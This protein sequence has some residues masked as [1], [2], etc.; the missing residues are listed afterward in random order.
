MS[1]LA[2]DIS[3]KYKVDNRDVRVDQSIDAAAV[4]YAGA[5]VGINSSSHLGRQ[6]VSGDDFAG[7][8]DAQTNNVANANYPNLSNNGVAIGAAGALKVPIRAAGTL[9]VPL[10]SITGATGAANI[11]AKVYATDSNTL[12]LT[13]SGASEIGVIQNYNLEGT[14]NF[15]IFFQSALLRAF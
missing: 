13:A 3:R 12:T 8:A 10:A 9:T 14:G 2:A 5:M 4:I 15:E 1:Q 11:K 7:F 6:L